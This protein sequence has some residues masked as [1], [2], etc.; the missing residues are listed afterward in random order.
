VSYKTSRALA[1]S[2]SS[3]SI[4][5]IAQ[6][7]TKFEEKQI[8]PKEPHADELLIKPGTTRPHEHLADEVTPLTA[9]LNLYTAKNPA[10]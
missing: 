5:N 9:A 3:A 6:K 2:R 10:K 1:C 4:F 7:N 8:D